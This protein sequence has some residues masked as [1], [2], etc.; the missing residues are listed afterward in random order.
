MREWSRFLSKPR[1]IEGLCYENPIRM[2]PP[3]TRE[4]LTVFEICNL[5]SWPMGASTRL[6]G[7]NEVL[8]ATR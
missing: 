2:K 5:L 1:K 7:P 6:F 3:Q 4:I 8:T